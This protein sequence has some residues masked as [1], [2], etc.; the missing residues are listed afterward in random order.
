M[1]FFIIGIIVL[2]GLK[3]KK[4]EED[5]PLTGTKINMSKIDTS[6]IEID[7]DVVFLEVSTG[8]EVPSLYGYF[9]N[10][11]GEKIYYNF[12]KE[13][14]NYNDDPTVLLEYF[15]NG[16]YGKD[17]DLLWLKE[18]NL[19]AKSKFMSE[20]ELKRYYYI[21]N[22]LEPNLKYYSDNENIAC[23]AS[24]IRIY[25]VSF[26]KNK[27]PKFILLDESFGG[28]QICTDRNVKMIVMR[29]KEK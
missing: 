4:S 1:L 24:I 23:D 10:K 27:S 14:L 13:A 21:L 8:T 16:Y 22:H 26:D 6:K 9:I 20:D 5:H 2:N 19:E 18:R 11:N 3:N 28:S 25:G 17:K 29:L 7:Q 12:S 15:A